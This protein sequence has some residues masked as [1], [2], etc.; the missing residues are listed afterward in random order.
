MFPLAIRSD[1][2]RLFAGPTEHLVD[3]VSTYV[4]GKLN[5]V[6]IL[7]TKQ[8]LN[9][10]GVMMQARSTRGE[11]VGEWEIAAVQPAVQQHAALCPKTL[12]HASGELK[13]IVTTYL[14]RAPPA[15][16]GAI[17]IDALLKVGDAN[18]DANTGGRFWWPNAA[19]PLVL[20]EGAA[21]RADAPVWLRSQSGQDCVA[22]CA[23]VGMSC[24]EPLLQSTDDRAKLDEQIRTEVRCQLPLLS[25]CDASGA[26][27]ASSADDR[28]Y[29]F[30]PEAC[31]NRSLAASATVAKCSAISTQ[32]LLKRRLCPCGGAARAGRLLVNDA[33]SSDGGDR[34]SG[35]SSSQSSSSQ[36]I[37]SPSSTLDPRRAARG[38]LTAMQLLLIALLSPS[39]YRSTVLLLVFGSALPTA[40]AHN[41]VVSFARSQFVAQT[42]GPCPRKEGSGPH[43]QVVAG[44]LFDM[45][46]PTAHGD[47]GIFT[48]VRAGDE[49]KLAT[50]TDADK[51]AY[52]AGCPENFANDAVM[53]KYHRKATA[54]VDLETESKPGFFA[55]VIKPG[56]PDFSPRHPA[57][58]EASNNA[59]SAFVRFKDGLPGQVRYKPA[60]TARDKRCAYTNPKMPFV[61]EMSAFTYEA[62]E[63][64]QSVD[65]ARF[66]IGRAPGDKPFH[67]N[68][69]P[70][71]YV[72]HFQW[73]GY[74]DCTDV[75]LVSGTAP[76]PNPYGRLAAADPDAPATYNQLD[77]CAL[78]VAQVL[79][80]RCVEVVDDAAECRAMCDA[81]GKDCAGVQVANIVNPGAVN[82]LMQA[83]SLA[84]LT[85]NDAP[86]T[87]GAPFCKGSAFTK[88]SP[89][90]RA[91]TRVCFAV[92]AQPPTETQGITVVTGDAQDPVYYATCFKKA[93]PGRDFGAA[94]PPAARPEEP[95]MT[96]ERC[97]SCRKVTIYGDLS[98]ELPTWN[99]ISGRGAPCVD[100]QLEPADIA[101]AGSTATPAQALARVAAANPAFDLLN[102]AAAPGQTRA[103]KTADK[104]PWTLA[105][106][107]KQCAATTASCYLRL[108]PLGSANAP[109]APET[110]FALANRETQC[111]RATVTYDAASR[112]CSCFKTSCGTCALTDA[113]ANTNVQVFDLGAPPTTTPKAASAMRSGPIAASDTPID[114]SDP[115]FPLAFNDLDLH[116]GFGEV[117]TAESAQ[118]ISTST[119]L[120]VVVVAAAVLAIGAVLKIR[121]ASSNTTSTQVVNFSD[122][123][124]KHITINNKW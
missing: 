124:N 108:L 41:W 59:N 28:C 67:Q 8:G 75:N 29:F 64:R 35:R 2:W 5:R 110:C 71:G 113:A 34:S 78:K 56:D 26:G 49:A 45:E 73:R 70:G 109:V 106:T 55:A 18:V 68:L 52:L 93:E 57:L 80:N 89:T 47:M 86:P 4:P 37:S 92:K 62:L 22:A 15:G 97:L 115:D 88:L 39:L 96:G 121:Q 21:P 120:I 65:S 101:P 42:N 54:T 85:D 16:S 72:V 33:S 79:N 50:L 20:Q 74:Q 112:K 102:P 9:F 40:H 123:N 111:N 30:K 43:V 38:A 66:R 76:V 12:L 84:P 13:N 107:G 46:W 105:A 53:R 100:C 122:N 95:F 58:I 94:T 81:A 63:P 14:F 10:R 25:H 118:P 119:T 32:N 17:T 23:A 7:V 19:G 98:G 60:Q 91:A 83:V 48:T 27:A 117:P 104:L 3:A 44:Q 24:N 36:S 77:H 90:Q 114:T 61:L 82:P 11:L 103:S 69:V 6:R 87:N 51:Q 116:L 1:N 99:T 31:V